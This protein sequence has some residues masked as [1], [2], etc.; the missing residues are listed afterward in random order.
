M[1]R[2]VCLIM[3]F[4]A[5]SL[6]G[7]EVDEIRKELA[8]LKRRAEDLEARLAQVAAAQSKGFEAD[9]KT[10]EVAVRAEVK[11]VETAARL[12]DAEEQIRQ[13]K[14]AIERFSS[15]PLFDKREH[16]EPEKAF[17][18]HGYARSGFAMNERGG[19]R[20]LSRR[21]EHSPSTGWVM[22][23]KRIRNWCL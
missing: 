2:G 11:A 10:L 21:Q 12:E 20:L 7:D 5:S 19:R 16:T 23:P 14:S 17:E 1:I 4:A 22:K 13:N 9:K 15:T 18:F 6:Y 3:C 8:E